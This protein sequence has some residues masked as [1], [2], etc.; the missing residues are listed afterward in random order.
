MFKRLFTASL[1]LGAAA[2]APPV[3][4]AQ[5]PLFCADRATV[6]DRLDQRFGERQILIG[7]TTSTTMLELW[8]AEDSG[9]FTVLITDARSRSCIMASGTEL[10]IDYP[11]PPG[12]DVRN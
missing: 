10:M 7:L 8:A 3:A 2:L 5:S 9:R 11:D 1:V 12:L 4:M 6:V